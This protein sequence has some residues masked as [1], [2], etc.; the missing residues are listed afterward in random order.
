MIFSRVVYDA[1]FSFVTIYKVGKCMMPSVLK[2]VQIWEVVECMLL[3]RDSGL[4]PN[5][6]HLE[7]IIKTFLYNLLLFMTLN[8][9]KFK[10]FK[11]PREPYYK[12]IQ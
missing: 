2:S 12:S 10:I 6:R 11:D 3:H 7:I 9:S 5:L 1:Q 4:Y 8:L